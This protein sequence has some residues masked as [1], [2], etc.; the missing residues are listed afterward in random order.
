MAFATSPAAAYIHFPPPTMQKMCR[1]STNIRV[2]SV[3]KFDNEKGIIVYNLVETLKG[4]NPKGM[5]F[6]HAMGQSGPKTQPILDWTSEGKRAVMFTI[7]GG[8]I[9]C[10]FVFIDE[11]C[12]SVDYNQKGDF[13]LLIRTDPEMAACYFGSAEELERVTKDLLAGK[14][15]MVPV[16]DGAKPLSS[17]ERRQQVPAINEILTNN[18]R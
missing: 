5:S 1:Q 18:R 9:F 8:A 6:R 2:L 12:Y 17:D 7:E 15:V 10:G 16:K 4:T 11:Y 14:E 3:E 13:W